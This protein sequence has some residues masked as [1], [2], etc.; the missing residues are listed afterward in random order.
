[1][2]W[3]FLELVEDVNALVAA[4]HAKPQLIF[5]HSTRCSISTG[6]KSR[7]DDGLEE[8]GERFD[9]H[10]LDLLQH[11]DISNFIASELSVPHESP[12]VIVIHEGKAVYDLSHYR[13]A[14]STLMEA[15]L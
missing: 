10:F 2:A 9:L 7:L 6:A 5:K 14:P 8:M 12:Q 11:R 4:S 13:I 3:N 1:M 15:S